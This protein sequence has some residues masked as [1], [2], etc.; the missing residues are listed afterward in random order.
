[1][2]ETIRSATPAETLEVARQIADL[3][4]EIARLRALVS[5]AVEMLTFEYTAGDG[6]PEKFSAEWDLLL[7]QAQEGR[8]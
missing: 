6:V 3:T 4:A 5:M 7:R 2:D 8:G 1:M